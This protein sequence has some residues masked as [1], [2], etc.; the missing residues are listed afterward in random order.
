MNV[1]AREIRSDKMCRN[2][3]NRRYG[4]SLQREHC[5]Y[6]QYPG[7]CAS[8]GEVR[9]IVANVVLWHRWRLWFRKKK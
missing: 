8:C 3:I 2:C 9:N 1:I 7:K 5:D 4:L 6:W